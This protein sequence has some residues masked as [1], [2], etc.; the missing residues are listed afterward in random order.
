MVLPVDAF[1]LPEPPLEY[2]CS[3][4]SGNA[5]WVSD[6]VAGGE[7]AR[8]AGIAAF[9]LGSSGMFAT[10]YSTQAILPELGREFDVSPARAGL[11]VSTVVLAVAVGVYLWGPLSDR[12]GRRRAI[13]LASTLLI[14]PTIAAGLAPTFGAVLVCRA[15]Q[16]LCLPGLLAVGVPY[17]MEAFG[18]WLG[19]RAMG[20]YVSALVAGGLIGRVGVALVTAAV[21]WRWAVGGLAVLPAAGVVLMRRSLPDVGAPARSGSRGGGIPDQLRNGTLLRIALAAGALFFTFVGVFS[22][23]TFRLEQPPFSFGTATG[24]LIFLL[25]VIGAVGPWAGKL[26][27]RLGWRPTALGAAACAA[28]GIALSV[29]DW[30]PTLVVGLGLVTLAMF[31]GVTALQLGVT[32]STLVDRGAA[33]AVYFSVYYGSGAIGAYVPG[34]AW[35]AWGWTGVALVGLSAVGIASLALLSVSWSRGLGKVAADRALPRPGSR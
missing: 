10:M 2:S 16:G 25:W 22:Y 11:T 15:L 34:L 33:T 21:G 18:P 5:V 20:I 12:I 8:T 30:L 4:P 17:V 3:A 9:L 24:S 35:Q 29:P 23:V 27:D 32:E 1:A 14:A 6:L 31:G 19:G 7:G 28:T 13:L 26:V